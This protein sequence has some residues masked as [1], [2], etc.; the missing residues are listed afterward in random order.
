MVKKSAQFIARTMEASGVLGALERM[1]TS[2]GLRV[3]TYHRVDE[4]SAEPDLDPGLI[5]ATPDEFRVQ[6]QLVA[7]H[8]HPVSL[9]TV[10]AAQ[11]GEGSLPSSG[12]VL[13]TF[14]DGY[15]DFALHAWPVLRDLGLPAVLFVPTA[16]PDQANGSGFWWDK[17]HAGLRR[18]RDRVVSL[19]DL[20]EFDLAEVTGRRLA[21]KS[22]KRH[23]KS[24][25]HG[26]AMDWVD[27]A[28]RELTDIPPLARVLSWDS[29]RELARQGLDVGV[30]GHLHALCTRLTADELKE[31]LNA[32]RA[33]L[34]SELGDYAF[35]SVIAWPANASSHQVREIARGLGFEMAFGG[36]RG[37]TRVPVPDALHVMRIPVLRYQQA[38]FRAQLRP[39]IA[40]L[41]RWVV[42]RPWSAAVK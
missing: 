16:F 4:P 20:G 30:H 42:D 23:V 3:L 31:D 8:Y 15:L 32:C 27:A 25:P 18:A 2:T 26:A 6:M 10:L 38:L 12:A 19:P 14:D 17:L 1:D 22:C 7:K 28:L 33:R 11:R 40:G 36:V 39:S 5:S 35:T 37:V 9:R 29:L 21:L 34:T 13:I 41:G 24:L